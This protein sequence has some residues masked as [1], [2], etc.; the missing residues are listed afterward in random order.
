MAVLEKYKGRVSRIPSLPPTTTIPHFRRKPSMSSPAPEQTPK[1]ETTAQKR[2]RLQAEMAELDAKEAREAKEKEERE[3]KEAEERRKAREEEERKEREAREAREERERKARE[4]EEA[5]E[6]SEEPEETEVTTATTGK[7]K[8]KDKA[9][10][11]VV[12]V[13]GDDED[14]DDND[15]PAGPRKHVASATVAKK[16]RE[17]T[18]KA[19]S[20]KGR[21][22]SKTVESGGE[23]D[24]EPVPKKPKASPKELKIGELKPGRCTNCAA[25]NV[26]CFFQEVGFPF[27]FS[28]FSVLTG[29]RAKTPGPARPV[30]GE[31]FPART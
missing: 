21:K 22:R 1:A 5:R 19:E 7:G 14:E 16:A 13:D 31:N 12:E 15:P 2:A 3:A 28:A 27:S 29:Y 25:L 8:G 18:A 26:D 10:D 24:E 30:R 6:A 17:K 4:E 11:D 9:D 23:E 20:K